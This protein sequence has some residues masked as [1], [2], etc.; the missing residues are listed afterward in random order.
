MKAITTLILVLATSLFTTHAED[1]PKKAAAAGQG[2]EK[3]KALMLQKFDT[4]KNGVIDPE[5][6]EAAKQALQN[7][8]GGSPGTAPAK[9]GGKARRYCCKNLMPTRM[10]CSIPKNVLR[11]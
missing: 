10:A 8:K 3:L 2:G 7:R 11:L 5:E 9:D 4:N 1:V 6:R